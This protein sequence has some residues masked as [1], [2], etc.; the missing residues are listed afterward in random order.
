M[1]EHK[2]LAGPLQ[3]KTCKRGSPRGP[4][5]LWHIGAWPLVV[6]VPVLVAGLM[7]NFVNM[8]TALVLLF[9]EVDIRFRRETLILALVSACLLPP[10]W[11]YTSRRGGC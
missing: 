3:E 11:A 1:K 2:A 4:A 5:G 6:K 10:R 8:A 9:F 7:V